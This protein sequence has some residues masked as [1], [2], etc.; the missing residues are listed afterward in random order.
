MCWCIFL[1]TACLVPDRLL[2]C[3]R[4][5]AQMSLRFL[6]ELHR[7]STLTCLCLRNLHW[8]NRPPPVRRSCQTLGRTS[9]ASSTAL[10]AFMSLSIVFPYVDTVLQTPGVIGDGD[11]LLCWLRNSR[12]ACYFKTRGERT[13]HQEHKDSEPNKLSVGSLNL[14]PRSKPTVAKSWQTQSCYG[15]STALLQNLTVAKSYQN[16]NL[17]LKT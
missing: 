9:Q 12:S 17:K 1:L 3:R 10:C 4:C 15:V 14:N 2:V 6:L 8:W 13:W 11:C 5:L 16:L 7:W